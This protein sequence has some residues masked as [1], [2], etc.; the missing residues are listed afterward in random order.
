MELINKLLEYG[1]A[2]IMLA[3]FLWKDKQSFDLYSR[4]MDKIVERLEKMQDDVDF[5]KETLKKK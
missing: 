2:G 4:T 3:Y 5:L 1:L